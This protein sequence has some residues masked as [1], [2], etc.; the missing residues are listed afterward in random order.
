[1]SFPHLDQLAVV[2]DR[3]RATKEVAEALEDAVEHMEQKEVANTEFVN[4]EMSDVDWNNNINLKNIQE[5]CYGFASDTQSPNSMQ[6]SQAT[7]FSSSRQHRSKRSRGTTEDDPSVKV[8]LDELSKL[9]S[10]FQ[11]AG[12]HM[13]HL[14]GVFNVE[15]KM[16]M[17]VFDEILKIERLTQNERMMVGRK[18]SSDV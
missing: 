18:F 17:K 8:L 6:P 12:D 13:K 4:E 11:I 10:Y 2:F 3:N 1:M 16:R 15:R 9:G 14:A 5:D 7:D